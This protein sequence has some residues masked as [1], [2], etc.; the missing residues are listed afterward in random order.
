MR[1]KRDALRVS[2]TVR[3]EENG[4]FEISLSLEKGT[5]FSK[6]FLPDLYLSALNTQ[7]D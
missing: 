4:I 1:H 2:K 6:C 7:L 5:I 3:F